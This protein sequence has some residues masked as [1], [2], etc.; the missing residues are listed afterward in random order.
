MRHVAALLLLRRK[1]RTLGVALTLGLCISALRISQATLCPADLS[2]CRLSV[3]SYATLALTVASLLAMCNDMAPDIVLMASTTLLLLTRIITDQ[4]AL[5]GFCSPSVLAIGALFPVARALEEVQTVDRVIRP[6]LGRPRGHAQA[7]LR[8]CAP[9][10]LFSAFL[11][12]TPIVAMLITSCET[13]AA[14]S[15]L[16][17]SVLLMPLSFASMLGGM[18]TLIGTSTNLDPEPPLAPF[19]MFSMT[20]VS[21][22]AAIVGVGFLALL[23]PRLLARREPEDEADGMENDTQSFKSEPVGHASTCSPAVGGGQGPGGMVEV[24]WLER[25]EADGSEMV[26]STALRED[27]VVC[28]GD[29]GTSVILPESIERE[30]KLSQHWVEAAVTDVASA[31]STSKPPSTGATGVRKGESSSVDVPVSREGSSIVGSNETTKS[32]PD[33]HGGGG[34]TPPPPLLV[35]EPSHATACNTFLRSVHPNRWEKLRLRQGDKVGLSYLAEALPRL[36]ALRGIKIESFTPLRE[37]SV[38][39]SC[40]LVEACVR[41]G[42]P[43][44]GL[45][46][47]E[48]SQLPLLGQAVVWGARFSDADTRKRLRQHPS[49]RFDKREEAEHQVPPPLSRSVSVPQQ[50]R[51]IVSPGR[52]LSTSM[53]DLNPLVET[54]LRSQLAYGENEVRIEVDS[55]ESESEAEASEVASSKY[56][57]LVKHDE[58]SAVLAVSDTL[59]L[60]EVAFALLS[61]VPGSRKS[62]PTTHDSHGMAHRWLANLALFALLFLS[63]TELVPLLPLTLSL[64][65]ILVAAGCITVEQAWHSISFRVLITI[66]ASF[67]LGAALENTHISNL[68]ADALTVLSRSLPQVVFLGIIFLCTSLLSCIVSNS[69]TV[70]L[71][72]SVLRSVHVPGLS[73]SRMMLVMMIGASSAFATPLGYQTNLLVVS[74]GGYRFGD[75]A[76]LGGLLT[77]VVGTCV[78]VLAWIMPES[79]LS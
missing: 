4:Q 67:G 57:S 33:S 63:A 46:V 25:A 5:R 9:T 75:F 27:G 15:G 8:L 34:S 52:R 56:S 31:P 66:A 72:Y 32:T 41:L 12:N 76:Y 60:E 65:F 62:A 70:V 10:S 38:P 48:A 47:E 18:C 37:A 40:C 71:L 77:I 50:K 19:S 26:V 22:P 64:S 35:V 53:Q 11:N 78:S 23:A 79:I 58:A 61:E 29:V 6:I 30:T 55:S 17:V 13:W 51:K 2:L 59:L 73:A 54:A 68:I 20:P 42:S 3:G 14:N 28:L 44:V 74:R 21:A 43:L 1:K 45:T 39:E 24:L 69:A 7:I 16:N 49:R 36:R